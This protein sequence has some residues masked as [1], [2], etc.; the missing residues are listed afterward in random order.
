MGHIYLRINRNSCS[1]KSSSKAFTLIEMLIV[2]AIIAILASLLLPVLQNAQQSAQTIVCTN[3]LKNVSMA[4]TMYCEDNSGTFCEINYLGGWEPNHYWMTYLS[5]YLNNGMTI[6]TTPGWDS[7][8]VY[9]CPTHT[10]RLKSFGIAGAVTFAMSYATG[11]NLTY[12]DRWRKIQQ[13]KYPSSSILFSEAGFNSSTCACKLDPFWLERSAYESPYNTG[14]SYIGGVHKGANN[15]AWIDGHV[16]SWR[17][18]FLLCAPP[19]TTAGD[20]NNHW[21]RGL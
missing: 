10:D 13:F 12:P 5:S 17:D 11:R 15:I 6:N 21:D 9:K 14:G 18:V 20:P 4:S 8:N 7:M 16:S 19:Y 2:V 1:R 3:N